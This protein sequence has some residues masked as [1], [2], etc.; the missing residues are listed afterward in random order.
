MKKR[1]LFI[2]L[3]VAILT[4]FFVLG[5]SATTIYKDTNGTELFRY[6]VYT[7]SDEVTAEKGF[8]CDEFIGTIKSYEGS[9]PKTDLNGNALTW[10]VTSTEQDEKGNTIKNVASYVTMDPEWC[11]IAGDNHYTF[12]TS[13]GVNYRNVVSINFPNDS[14]KLIRNGTNSYGLYAN[15]GTFKPTQTELLFAYFPNTYTYNSAD[16]L[17][18]A[19]TVIEVEFANGVNLEKISDTAFYSCRNLRKITIPKSVVE[20]VGTNG[21]FYQCI[22]MQSVTFEEG[23][24]LTKL[25]SQIFKECRLLKEVKLPNTV[26]SMGERTFEHCTSLEK[27]WLGASLQSTTGYSVFRLSNNLKI[28]YVPSTFTSI[29]QHTFTHDSGSGPADTVF[30][31]AGT[32]AQFDAFYNA[33]VSGKNNER[34]T[35]GY[36][37]EYVVEWD[38]TK[39]DSYYTNL[40]TTEG[41]KL[42]VINYGI[43]D[44]FYN[45][46]HVE[47]LNE[48]EIDTNPCVITLCAQCKGTN[49]DSSSESTHSLNTVI[50]YANGFNLNGTRTTT[51]QHAGC[52][53]NSSESAKPEAIGAIFTGFGISTRIEDDSD[54][55]GIAF[56]M[57]IDRELL[58]AYE[59]NT[60][61]ALSYGVLT[62]F[63]QVIGTNNPL[64]NTG[65]PTLEKGIVATDVSHAEVYAVD[66]VLKG[67]KA[68]WEEEAYELDL[69]MLGYTV[70]N[71]NV[72][73][74]G[75]VNSVATA[76]ANV[77]DLKTTTYKEQI[78]E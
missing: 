22:N 38:P 8:K 71:G 15:T 24:Q 30:F 31:Y 64:D 32:R 54:L 63:A 57:L 37:D 44:A 36:K 48:G 65:T 53:Y 4:C 26:T 50:A 6:E 61:T 27:I 60:G 11:T 59:E 51:C 19:T 75:T 72:T 69:Y 18:Q 66:L 68:L 2:A 29:Y 56:T 17:V 45:G 9:F 70:E 39:P 12:N 62:T 7:S 49:L 78:G 41:H 40:A 33:A 10:Y 20:I 16:R 76:S 21:A 74:M 73:Y 34:V 52:A 5:V 42:Y 14:I 77:S 55:R 67:T 25:G 1:L 43:C 13:K 23:S 3:M 28:Y 35:S 47:K 58:A 46:I